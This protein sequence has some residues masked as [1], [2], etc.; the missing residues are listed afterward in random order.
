MYSVCVYEMERFC[1]LETREKK[2]RS[3]LW[4]YHNHELWKFLL[5]FYLKC[6]MILTANP[7]KQLKI[8]FF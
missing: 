3:K 2:N 7:Y 4:S 8:L 1:R 5:D 6:I